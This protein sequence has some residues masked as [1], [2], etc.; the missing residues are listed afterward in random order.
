MLTTNTLTQ[1]AAF[2]V[3]KEGEPISVLKLVK[4]AYLADRE[5]MYRYGFPL[6]LD[7]MVSMQHGPVLSHMLNLINRDVAKVESDVWDQWISP[8][9]NDKV[10]LKKQFTR[11]DLD[12]I[13]ENDL[14]VL[15]DVW[16]KFGHMDQWQLRDYT[17]DKCSEW[18]DPVNSGSRS[19]PID[20][21][22]VFRAVGIEEKEALELAK[23]VRA[24]RSLDIAFSQP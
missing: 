23:E 19:M 21:I 10:A 7:N 18:R 2:F 1:M 11:S 3:D 12:Y 6:S 4:L 9:E 5:A 14:V 20:E 16:K 22:D 17:H 15:E 8:R 13:S 24:E